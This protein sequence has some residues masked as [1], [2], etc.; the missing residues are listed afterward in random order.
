MAFD[1]GR[2]PLRPETKRLW[3]ARRTEAAWRASSGLRH[4]AADRPSQGW[5]LAWRLA[6]TMR[7]DD[8]VAAGTV[9][10]LA[11]P[12]SRWFADLRRVATYSPVVARWTTLNDFFHL[13]DRP[14]E[15]FSP[16]PDE[17]VTPYLTQ[18]VARGD[19]DPVS[20]LPRHRRLRGRVDALRALEALGRAIASAVGRG[21]AHRTPG[22]C[23]RTSR[24]SKRSRSTSSCGVRQTR[25]GS[26]IAPNR[27]GPPRWLA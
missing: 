1:A 24:R 22:S 11:E 26:S 27:H 12:P 8:H 13:T 15:T 17:Y 25:S 6:A 10:P 5:R 18:A 14:Y 23:R 7:V 4:L 21:S 20:W 19:A 9:R 2:F 16:E 3:E